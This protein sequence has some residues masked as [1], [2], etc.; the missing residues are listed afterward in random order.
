[1]L[2]KQY[3]KLELENWNSRSHIHHESRKNKHKYNIKTTC[4]HSRNCLMFAYFKRIC[5]IDTMEKR[6][7]LK[8]KT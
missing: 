6:R 5:N 1:M 4:G 8:K 7:F 3:G 2:G